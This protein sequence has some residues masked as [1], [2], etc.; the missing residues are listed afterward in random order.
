MK[1]RSK[2]QLL[3]LL[4]SSLMLSLLSACSPGE[5]S[6]T[7]SDS[8]GKVDEFRSYS[9]DIDREKVTFSSVFEEVEI[10]Q[11]E[12]TAESLLGNVTQLSQIERQFIFPDKDRKGV[13]IFSDQGKYRHKFNNSGDGEGEYGTINDLWL[14]GDSIVIYDAKKRTAYWYNQKGGFLKSEKMPE[15][16]G[17]IYPVPEGFLADMTFAPKTDS[18][19]YMV[20]VLDRELQTRNKLIPNV[21]GI[22][23]TMGQFGNSFKLYDDKLIFKPVYEDTTYFINAQKATP[24]IQVDFGEK[25]LWKDK[26]LTESLIAAMMAIPEGNGVWNY[27]SYIGSELIYLSYSVALASFGAL[28]DRKTGSYVVISTFFDNE[29]RY[30]FNPLICHGD[31]FLFSMPSTTALALVDQMEESQYRFVEGTT[32]KRIDQSENPV[33]MWVK[34]K[35]PTM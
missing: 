27:T 17:H 16:T 24:L 23:F 22:L 14:S 2:N 26:S 13:Y 12:E 6:E 33:L 25:Y 8:A 10:I 18:I 19:P 15:G 20:W 11:L 29:E 35:S 28:I 1:K 9:I 7:T 32:L 21:R 34:F 31:R 3:N 30:D 4:I 5:N